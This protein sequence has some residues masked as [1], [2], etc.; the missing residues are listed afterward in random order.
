MLLSMM[1]SQL[2]LSYATR[3]IQMTVVL[4]LLVR[5]AFAVMLLFHLIFI[6]PYMIAVAFCRLQETATH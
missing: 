1:S 3:F 6:Y 4:A 5:V 2:A